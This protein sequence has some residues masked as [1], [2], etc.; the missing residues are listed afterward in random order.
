MNIDIVS[1]SKVIYVL[2]IPLSAYVWWTISRCREYHPRIMTLFV[3][4]S[5]AFPCYSIFAL[6][7]VSGFSH[8][9]WIEYNLF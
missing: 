2:T 3:V 5:V 4:Q 8:P 9:W 6:F 1:L 7:Y